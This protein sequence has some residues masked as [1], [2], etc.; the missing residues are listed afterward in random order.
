MP[1][2]VFLTLEGR[3]DSRNQPPMDLGDGASMSDL[4]TQIS[5][6]YGGQAT[7]LYL[8][9]NEAPVKPDDCR[10][11]SEYAADGILKVHWGCCPLVSVAVHYNDKTASKGFPPGVVVDRVKMFAA[12]ELDIPEADAAELVLKVF[13]RDRVAPA[14][15]P[16]G[17]L[18]DGGDCKVV[19]DLVPTQRPQG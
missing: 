9:G 8:P 17:T 13:G 15:A 6:K 4:V 1:T 2:K 7:A 18:V 14:S 19:F 3:L 16:I 11:V 12:G 5:Q 10:L